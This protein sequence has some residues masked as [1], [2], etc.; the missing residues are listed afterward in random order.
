M[1]I[2]LKTTDKL[3]YPIFS[4]LGIHPKEINSVYQDDVF[5]AALF[6]IAKISQ[7]APQQMN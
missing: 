3:L 1:K 6:T 5:I 7:P 4:L 2:A